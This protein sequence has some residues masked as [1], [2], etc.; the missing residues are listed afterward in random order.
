MDIFH[1]CITRLPRQ[2]LHGN[3]RVSGGGQVDRDRTGKMPSRKISGK[4]ASAGTRLKK[5]RRTG[6]ARGIVSPNAS[7]TRDEPGTSSSS[8]SSSSNSSFC[9]CC[10]LFLYAMQKR[11]RWTARLSWRRI[12]VCV[13]RRRA[14]CAWTVKLTRCFYLADTWSAATPAHLHCVIVPCAGPTSEAP[15]RCSWD[16]KFARLLV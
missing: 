9:F 11:T 15:S 13:M 12:G 6:G 7:S 16:N 2:T 1:E 10:L 8:S 3:P 4:W 14:R 5:L